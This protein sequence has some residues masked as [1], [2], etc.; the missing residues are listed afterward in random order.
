MTENSHK[1]CKI[2]KLKVLQCRG[3]HKQGKW[4]QSGPLGAGLRRGPLS[5][6]L[7]LDLRWGAEG[8]DPQNRDRFGQD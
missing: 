7:M 2:L 3:T 4:G 6:K 8:A 1:I 5:V